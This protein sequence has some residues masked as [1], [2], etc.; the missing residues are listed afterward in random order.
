VRASSGRAGGSRRVTP[1]QW[2]RVL[3]AGRNAADSE[4]ARGRFGPEPLVLALEAMA[5]EAEAI[6]EEIR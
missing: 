4:A 3:R 2:A 6:A 1:Q 5:Y